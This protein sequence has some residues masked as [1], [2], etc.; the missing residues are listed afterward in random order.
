MVA[1]KEQ[2]GSTETG[3]GS[4]TDAVETASPASASASASASGT[5]APGKKQFKWSVASIDSAFKFDHSVAT[6]A[7]NL[8]AIDWSEDNVLGI[9]R[10]DKGSEGLFFVQTRVGGALVVKRSKAIG[11]E[12]FCTLLALR[13]GIAAPFARIVVTTAPDGIA[14]L[15]TLNRKDVLGRVATTLYEQFYLILMQYQRGVSFGAAGKE[16]MAAA[17]ADS[18]HVRQLGAILALDVLVNN[19]DRLPLIWDHQGNAGNVMLNERNQPISIDGQIVGLS[20]ASGR[21]EYMARVVGLL[22]A[23]Q[24][25]RT[26]T[27]AAP[28]FGAVRSALRQHCHVDIGVAGELQL[29]DGF[30]SIVRRAARGESISGELTQWVGLLARFEPALSD[31]P[32]IQADFVDEVW[33]LFA[34]ESRSVEPSEV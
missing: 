16:R 20:A 25:E 32:Q 2:H 12:I 11:S 3:S 5:A 9:E 1:L 22:R 17:L 27:A 30:W 29:E 24:P 21:A 13:L 18:E 23:R 26:R 15:S 4:V 33:S 7:T 10:A 31:L 6:G 34:S 14:M 28:Q 19:V 8:A